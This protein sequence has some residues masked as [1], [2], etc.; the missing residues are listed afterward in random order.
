MARKTFTIKDYEQSLIEAD[1]IMKESNGHSYMTILK[2]RCQ[3]CGR[4]PRD[5]R[6]CGQWF[7]TFIERQR[8]YFLN[9]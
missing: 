7:H 1:K 9:L 8:E 3:F 5:K 4:S 2:T 6:R